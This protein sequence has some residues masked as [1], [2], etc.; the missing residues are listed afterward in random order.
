MSCVVKITTLSHPL[1]VTPK[2]PYRENQRILLIVPQH[3]SYLT[4][5]EELLLIW[6]ASEAEEWINR[7]AY[8]PL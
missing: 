2:C 8:F 6:T 1:E 3:L 5:V 7:I 4:V